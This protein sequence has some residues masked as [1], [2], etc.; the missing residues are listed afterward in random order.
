MT[1]LKQWIHAFRLRTLFLAVATVIMASGMAWHAGEFN[2]ITFILAF[3]LALSIQILANLA[4]DLGDYQ[5]GTDTTGFRQGPGRAVQSGMISP[6]E[7]KG[8]ILLFIIICILLGLALVLNMVNQIEWPSVVI[9]ILVGSC[10][11]LAALFYTLGGNAY[12][13]RGWG[14][15]FAFLFFGP[16]PVIGTWFLHTHTFS[17]QP[18]LPAVSLGLI[19][20]MILNVNNMRDIENDR[21]SGKI[22]IAVKLGLKQAKIYHALMTFT[23]FIC[24]ALYNILYEPAP[25][26]RYVYLLVFLIPFSILNQIRNKSGHQLDPYLKMTSLS[27]FLLAA[28]FAISINI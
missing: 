3:L 11:I 9:L 27:G 18:L 8:A 19:S 14:D 5:K 25:C 21:A 7:M 16:V 20:T 22:T 15:L 24:L 26:Y 10:S 13:Y 6:A 17:V 2:S 23:S 28:A 4:N 1:R 12:G